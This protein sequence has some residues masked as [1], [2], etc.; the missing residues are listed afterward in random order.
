LFSSQGTVPHAN[1]NSAKSG[2]TPA[3]GAELR[4]QIPDSQI[5]P[6]ADGGC[7]SE[8][9]EDAC[10]ASDRYGEVR[11]GCKRSEK[12]DAQAQKRSARTA[13]RG[14]WSY[15]GRRVCRGGRKVSRSPP[16]GPISNR[17]PASSPARRA[18][19]MLVGSVESITAGVASGIHTDLPRAV[20]L[21]E[22][23]AHNQQRRPVRYHRSSPVLRCRSLLHCRRRPSVEPCRGPSHHRRSRER[24]FALAIS[25]P[26]VQSPSALVLPV[27]NAHMI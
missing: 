24:Q 10:L 9:F 17:R 15:F 18:D 7:S 11:T 8:H 20:R 12:R 14:D 25:Q 22:S 6:T 23:R 19:L 27:A 13:G 26:S 2:R 1:R 21:A 3:A 4:S 16:P 5:P